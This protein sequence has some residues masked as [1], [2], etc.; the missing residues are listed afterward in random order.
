[1]GNQHPVTAVGDPC[2]SIYTWRGASA[3]TISAFEKN[4]PPALHEIYEANPKTTTFELLTTYRNDKSILDLQMQ[5][6]RAYEQLRNSRYIRLRH[7]SELE[8]ESSMLQPLKISMLK[9]KL[10]PNTLHRSGTTRN[11]KK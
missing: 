7:A 5:S 9:H 3:G 1:F 11:A 10:L 8:L 2:Q 6:L 4:F